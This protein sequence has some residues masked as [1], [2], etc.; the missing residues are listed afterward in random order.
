M[1]PPFKSRYCTWSLFGTKHSSGFDDKLG[2]SMCFICI[3]KIPSSLITYV[4]DW[5]VRLPKI[6][7]LRSFL[8]CFNSQISS[9]TISASMP[10]SQSL[11]AILL[12]ISIA[13][14]NSVPF[15]S[16]LISC[17]MANASGFRGYKPHF[18][19]PFLI[20]CSKSILERTILNN[21]QNEDY[22]CYYE[23]TLLLSSD[24]NC[25]PLMVFFYSV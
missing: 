13:M 23:T 5:I 14:S 11:G 24:F 19:N 3:F 22:Y 1:F 25:H 10:H 20:V 12:I 2:S 18:L 15:I 16:V 9:T 8:T 4:H 7:I 6:S 17:S 21:G